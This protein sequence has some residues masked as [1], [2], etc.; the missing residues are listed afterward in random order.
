M[1]EARTATRHGAILFD[2]D[3]L[4]TV[5]D[6]AFSA[7]NWEASEPVTGSFKT[8]GRNRTMIVRD[9]QYEFVLR[10]FLRGGAVGRLVRGSYLWLGEDAT[11]GFA[12][13]RL[14]VKLREMRLPVPQPAAARFRR[15]GLFYSADILTVRVP[16]IRSLSD[17]LAAA[18]VDAQFW[19][20]LGAGIYRFH[21]AGVFHADLNVSNVQ[22]NDRDELCLL[23]FDR[24]RLLPAGPWRQKNLA[25]FHRSL[26]KLKSFDPTVRFSEKSW[27]EFLKG[28]FAASRSA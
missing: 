14:L 1:R 5:S 13:F 20:E 24:G 18:E 22:L 26:R 8:A 7:A 9:G 25:R 23:D 3:I 19:H 15:H 21:A 17:R 12:E 2:A 11:R 28:Y 6:A 16:G 27:N 10:H 4:E